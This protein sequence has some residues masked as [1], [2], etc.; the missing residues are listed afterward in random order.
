MGINNSQKY[1]E[2]AQQFRLFR[3][4]GR[5]DFHIDPS[6]LSA[7]LK[8]NDIP[9]Y[10]QSYN[11]SP[12]TYLPV[13]IAQKLVL[14]QWGINFSFSNQPLINAR[15]DKLLLN[16]SIW[17]SAKQNRCVVYANGFYEWKRG[18]KGGKVPYYV[19]RS[20]GELMQFAGLFVGDEYVVVT[21]ESSNELSWLH[22][23]MPVILDSEHDQD[24]WAA[25]DAWSKDLE[26]LLKPKEGGL[27]WF[28]DSLI[29]RHAVS[30]YV[31][32]VGNDGEQCIKK[33]MEE[34]ESKDSAKI[35]NFFKPVSKD[36]VTP[37]KRRMDI[38]LEN[39]K[40]RTKDEEA[41]VTKVSAVTAK[42]VSVDLT[43]AWNCEACTFIN[44]ADRDRCEVCEK[45][46]F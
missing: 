24:K 18:A 43:N 32:K 42:K 9:P 45:A 41:C 5:C 38:A 26:D 14:K 25:G 46:R 39:V 31:G 30:K 35:T 23:R 44:S 3:M 8:I 20:D 17:Q 34:V 16:K 6:S 19:T 7:Q 22:D 15:N 28:V 10:K 4:C 27:S 33:V 2:M 36:S 11:V 12:R 1:L 13:R 21:C 29:C 40:K 37:S